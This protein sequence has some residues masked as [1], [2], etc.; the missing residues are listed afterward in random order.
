MCDYVSNWNLL[1]LTSRLGGRGRVGGFFVIH[2]FWS[3]QFLSEGTVQFTEIISESV[4]VH[5]IGNSVDVKM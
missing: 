5:G 2:S 3:I 1:Y 4:M